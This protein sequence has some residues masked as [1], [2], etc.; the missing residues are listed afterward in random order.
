MSN[1]QGE[2]QDI[3]NKYVNQLFDSLV[4]N[5]GVDRSVLESTWGSIV[6]KKLDH[7][8]MVNLAPID[9]GDGACDDNSVVGTTVQ[10]VPQQSTGPPPNPEIMTA[11]VAELKAMCKA[12]K[13][14]VGGK[15]QDLIDRLIPGGGG[16]AGAGGSTSASTPDKVAP[17]APKKKKR[18]PNRMPQIPIS[19]IQIKKNSHGNYE[20][21]ETKMIFEKDT[22]QVIGKQQDDGSI[23]TLTDE[24]I[25]QCDQF[26]FNYHIPEKIVSNADSKLS[27]KQTPG[28]DEIVE[29]LEDIIGSDEEEFEEFYEDA[30]D[31]AE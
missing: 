12:L 3:I 15:K 21:P 31:D 26:K 29:T 27:S 6:G 9:T 4:Q 28:E 16:G 14:S 23:S 24:D 30:E 25:Q 13:L 2:I 10:H 7:Q 5:N 20:H 19:S 1:L 18:S 22:K 17:P 8:R 11:N